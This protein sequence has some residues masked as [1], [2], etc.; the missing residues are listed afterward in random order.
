MEEAER[1]ELAQLTQ[2]QV[3]CRMDIRGVTFLFLW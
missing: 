2:I 1:C 3:E